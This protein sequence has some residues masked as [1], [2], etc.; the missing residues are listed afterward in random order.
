MDFAL[1]LAAWFDDQRSPHTRDAYRRDLERYIA[2]WQPGRAGSPLGSTSDDLERY[3]GDLTAE[4]LAPATVRRHLSSLRS[5]FDHAAA[6]GTI[7]EAPDV[8]KAPAAHP[9]RTRRRLSP[10]QVDVL[11]EAAG[12]RGPRERLL[13]A[14]LLFDDVRLHEVLAADVTDVDTGRDGRTRLDRGARGHVVVDART[15]GAIDDVVAGRD[16]GPLLLGEGSG[17]R[18]TRFGADYL[19]RRIS[20]AAGIV[21]AASASTLRA[22]AGA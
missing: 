8:P 18:L 11:V 22:V 2:W 19:I 3:R 14:L 6:S 5:F 4:G 7:T 12:E 15:A 1:A 17:D 13:L 16:A 9:P 21:P 20:A 10:A